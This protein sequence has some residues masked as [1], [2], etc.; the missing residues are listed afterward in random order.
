MHE[1][2]KLVDDSLEELPVSSEKTRILANNVHDVRCYDG[3][4]V[5]P[6]FLLTQAKQVLNTQHTKQMCSAHSENI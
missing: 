1:L 6:S 4:V 3:F 5:L 2:K